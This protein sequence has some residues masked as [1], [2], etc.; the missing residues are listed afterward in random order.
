MRSFTSFGMPAPFL[1]EPGVGVDPLAR[2]E[3]WRMVRELLARDRI[4]VWSTAYLDEAEACDTVLLLND[5]KLLYD[6][7]PEDLAKRVEGRVFLLSGAGGGR[8]KLIAPLMERRST[9]DAVIQ[10]SSVRVLTSDSGLLRASMKV[11]ACSPRG[12]CSAY[13]THG[14]ETGRKQPSL[15]RKS[16]V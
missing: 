7:T 16:V 6:G 1:D 8:R 4:V 15:D 14:Q 10:G 5:G 2:R 3:L 12:S 13:F 11:V 9:L